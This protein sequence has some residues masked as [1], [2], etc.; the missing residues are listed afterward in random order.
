MGL[1]YLLPTED[2]PEEIDGGRVEIKNSKL[3]LK[4]YGLPMI[5]WGYLAAIF[6]VV[7]AM[8]MVS[9]S[10]IH[11]MLTYNDVTLTLLAYLVQ[12]IFIIGPTTLLGFY[13]YEKHLIKNKNELEIIHRVFFIP[14][15]K[16]KLQLDSK[17]SF[18]VDHFMESPNVAKMQNK[19]ELRGF[20]N[21]GYFELKAIVNGKKM[22]IDR[23]SRKA[24]LIKIKD[25]LSKY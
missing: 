20:E 15:I 13:F 10:V 7:G 9:Q 23:S 12:T 6:I 2:S 17:D 14:L 24:D 3:T 22:M 1:M 25:L 18:V 5:F 16:K 8:A 11:K 21:K 19:D 4:S